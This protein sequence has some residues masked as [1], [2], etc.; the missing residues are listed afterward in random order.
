MA[1]K[2]TCL[3]LGVSA[4]LLAAVACYSLLPES[5]SFVVAPG[6]STRALRGSIAAQAERRER[7]PTA[8]DEQFGKPPP[9]EAP[10]ETSNTLFNFTSLLGFVVLIL[11]LGI[12]LGD[13]V[14]D[15]G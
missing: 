15:Q 8:R 3:A 12:T 2:I 7:E 1:R 10:F 13:R 11:F 9:T 5:D 6:T 4:L 14:G